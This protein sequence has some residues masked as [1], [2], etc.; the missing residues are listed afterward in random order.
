MNYTNPELSGSKPFSIGALDGL[1]H[2]QQHPYFQYVTEYPEK[3]PKSSPA[4]GQKVDN[5]FH[6]VGK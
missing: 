3:P 4:A 6:L 2:R 5:Y 1:N